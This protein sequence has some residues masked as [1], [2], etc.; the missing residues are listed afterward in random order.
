MTIAT[1]TILSQGQPLPDDCQLVSIDIDKQLNRIPDARLIVVDGDIAQRIFAV[2]NSGFFA[3]GKDIEVLLRH[4]GEED[5][6]VFK[7]LVVRHGVEAGPRG[8]KLMVELKDAAIKLTQPR[9]SV[10]F[11]DQSDDQIVSQI[12]GDAGLEAGDMASTDPVYPELV[13]YDASDWDFIV[14]RADVKGLVVMVDD[15]VLSLSP[16][17]ISGSPAYTFEYGLSTIYDL[18]LEI[19]ASRQMPSVA[20]VA[21]DVANQARTE[22]S[23]AADVTLSQG[24]LDGAAIADTIGFAASTLTHPV[25]ADPAELQAWADARMARSRLSMIRGTITVPGLPDI[26]PLSVVALNGV[27]EHFN[28]TVLVSGVRHVYQDHDWK[29][30]LRLGLSPEWFSHTDHIADAPAAGLLPPVT[31]LQIGVVDGFEAD[32]D[33]EYRVKVRLPAMDDEQGAVWARLAWAEAGAGR[34]YFFWPEPG[35][36][37]VVGFF[38]SDPRQPVV[39]G[40]MYSSANPPADVIGE[41]TEDN[42]NK[43]I[44]TKQ[45]TTIGFIDGDKAGVFIETAEGNKI[46]VDDDTQGIQLTD[47]NGNTIT[48]SSSGIELKSGGDI[49]I[50]AGGNVTIKGSAVDVK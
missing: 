11:R 36:E 27:S 39:L 21:W 10:V 47:Q 6:T 32:P 23:E 29:T 35:D 8:S 3:P 18:D 24:D 16:M 2:S 31:G 25:P 42:I 15:G 17:Q 43:G 13:Q 48:M 38:N 46:L 5:T 30:E 28:G 9:K 34:G 26:K 33:G 7:G 49:I 37:V 19:D 45:G 1:A 4:E 12:V 14:S 22:P 40:S 50:D 41:P 20:G 44:V